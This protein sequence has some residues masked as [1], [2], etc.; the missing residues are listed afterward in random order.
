MDIYICQ[1]LKHGKELNL[2][3][4]VVVR[5]ALVLEQRKPSLFLP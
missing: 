3:L 4:E 1:R 2:S 5:R